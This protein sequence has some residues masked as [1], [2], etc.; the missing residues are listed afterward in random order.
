MFTW[1]FIDTVETLINLYGGSDGTEWVEKVDQPEEYDPI[2]HDFDSGIYEY[3]VAQHD[4][5]V[6]ELLAVDLYRVFPVVP[7]RLSAVLGGEQQLVDC[8]A[9][10][11]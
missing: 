1:K 11:N 2:Q 8:S 10:G 3:F 7:L 4:S 6:T 5:G 9:M